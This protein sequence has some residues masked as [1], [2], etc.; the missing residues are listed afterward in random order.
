MSNAKDLAQE[1]LGK[2]D[3]LS[4][5][6]ALEAK[7][8]KFGRDLVSDYHVSHENQTRAVQLR[9]CADDLASLLRHE[10]GE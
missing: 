4:A 3:L 2:L 9:E 1:Y 10:G 7:W 5:L 6:R 8:R